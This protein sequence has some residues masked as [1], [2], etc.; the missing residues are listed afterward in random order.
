MQM[1]A[2]S[3]AGSP[4]VLYAMFMPGLPE[5][6]LFG[7]IAVLLFGKNLPDVARNFGKH[8]SDFRKGLSDMQSSFHQTVD[9]YESPQSYSPTSSYD[10]NDDRAEASAPKFEPPPAESSEQTDDPA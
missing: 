4:C 6:M 2:E 3:F 5:M 9:T 8:Y 1:V 10:E 7:V